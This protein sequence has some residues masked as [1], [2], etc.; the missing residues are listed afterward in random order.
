MLATKVYLFIQPPVLLAHHSASLIHLI[1]YNAEWM[2][3]ELIKIEW[4]WLAGTLFDTHTTRNIANPSSKCQ[5][6]N[7]MLHSPPS[8]P[9]HPIENLIRPWSLCC[10]D[11]AKAWRNIQRI[12]S[13]FLYLT[14]V[15][16]NVKHYGKAF[17][18][19]SILLL[20]FGL[21]SLENSQW[22]RM[23]P[24]TE[25]VWKAWKTEPTFSIMH[26]K[27]IAD[28]ISTWSSPD[29]RMKASGTT[30]W[31][32]TKCEITP[33]DVDTYW[34][35]KYLLFQWMLV[36]W[37]IEWKES[38]KSKVSFLGRFRIRSTLCSGQNGSLFIGALIQL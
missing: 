15:W 26:T 18:S 11:F 37:F 21:I 13:G 24:S 6:K 25:K 38:D 1:R 16:M 4:R 33:V 8:L 19:F 17:A 5:N 31:R 36:K 28:P 29:P 7:S 22:N 3:R 34:M 10:V 12:H 20:A 32:F 23:N 2:K 14:E 30:T 9:F 35:W 27:L